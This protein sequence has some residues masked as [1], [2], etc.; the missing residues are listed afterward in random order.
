V[1]AGRPP[2]FKTVEEMQAVIDDYFSKRS[3]EDPPTILG[4]C[5][6]LDME[7]I[8]LLRYE[9]KDEFSNTI[10]KAKAKVR[11]AVEHRLMTG[12]SAPAAAIFWLKNNAEWVDKIE[13][14]FTDKEG[15]DINVTLTIGKE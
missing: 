11:A 6:V 1:P 9:D 8:S 13:T 14:G 3:D 5:E 4:L 12:K 7:R 10:K 2:K 15:K